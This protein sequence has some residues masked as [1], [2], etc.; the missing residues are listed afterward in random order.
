MFEDETTFDLTIDG[1][2]GSLSFD[3]SSDELNP[4]NNIALISCCEEPIPIVSDVGFKAG[5]D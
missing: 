3:L 5:R 2:L 4:G 1:L